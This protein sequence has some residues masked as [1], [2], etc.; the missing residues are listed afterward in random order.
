MGKSREI[1]TPSQWCW[2]SGEIV[3]VGSAVPSWYAKLQERSLTMINAINAVDL[4]LIVMK[5]AHGTAKYTAVIET[6]L[7]S[8]EVGKKD[9]GSAYAFPVSRQTCIAESIA[10]NI[11]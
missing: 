10:T 6:H 4:N 1:W 3:A 7:R 9:I 2:R 5:G 11:S 8:G